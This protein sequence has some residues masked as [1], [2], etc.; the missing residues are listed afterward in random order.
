MRIEKGI[1]NG[2]GRRQGRSVA[3]V[4]VPDADEGAAW[5]CTRLRGSVISASDQGCLRMIE[6]SRGRFHRKVRIIGGPGAMEFW[7]PASRE[8]NP[9]SRARAVTDP[10]GN[11]V[12]NVRSR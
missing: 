11:T 5:W 7:Q 2:S 4:R 6:V 10:W 9:M 8:D 12:P 3:I 1:W